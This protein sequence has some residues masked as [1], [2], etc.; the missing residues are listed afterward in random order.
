LLAEELIK[1]VIENTLFAVAVKFVRARVK[2][3]VWPVI[4]NTAP[5][6]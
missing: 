2:F 3:A 6:V 1:R 5:F 4:K